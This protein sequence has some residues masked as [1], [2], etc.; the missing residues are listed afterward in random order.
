M[1]R[2]ESGRVDNESFFA[3]RREAAQHAAEQRVGSPEL[4]QPLPD[5]RSFLSI[6]DETNRS[7]QADIDGGT[8]SEQLDKLQDDI[9]ILGQR[10][11]RKQTM[12]VMAEYRRAV[13]D[14]LRIV[15]TGFDVEDHTSSHNILNRKR[16]SMAQVVNSKLERLAAGLFQTQQQ[17]LDILAAVE[18][19]QGL[20]VDLRH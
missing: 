3:F 7:E 14:F 2:V 15:V 20:L 4:P 10:L 6:L 19:I 5:T 17:P 16:Y 9:H 1:K 8:P 11:L 13:Q 18:E 12:S